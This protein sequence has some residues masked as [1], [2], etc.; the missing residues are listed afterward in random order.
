MST[1]FKNVFFVWRVS[2]YQRGIYIIICI[3]NIQQWPTEKYKQRSTRH[4]QKTR[5]EIRCSGRVSTS[6]STSG[7]SRVNLVTN[8]LIS[9]ECGKDWEVFVHPYGKWLKTSAFWL[10]CRNKIKIRPSSMIVLTLF[11]TKRTNSFQI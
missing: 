6:C 7:T 4:T 5:G 8:P 9:H 3:S 10:L 2:R 11:K 1:K